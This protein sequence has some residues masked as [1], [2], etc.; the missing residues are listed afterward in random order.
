MIYI[1]KKKAGNEPVVKPIV[2]FEIN[3]YKFNE[4]Q[5]KP[6][7]SIVLKINDKNV[8]SYGSMVVLTG[9]PKARKSTFLH[10]ILASAIS[11]Q[12]IFGITITMQ[13]KKEKIILIDT[14]QSNYELFSSIERLCKLVDI[15]VNDIGKYNLIIYSARQLDAHGISDLVENIL[16]QHPDCGILAVDGAIDLINDINDVKE[17]KQIIQK[18]KY[19]IDK[20]NILFITIIHQNKST[21]FSL[22][23][24]GSFASR[25]AQSELSIEK[26]DNND[27]TLSATYMRSDENF[28]PVMVYYDSDLKTYKHSYAQK[29]SVIKDYNHEQ[30]INKLFDVKEKYLFKDLLI[31]LK[32]NYQQ[33]EYFVKN[34]IVPMLFDEKLIVKTTGGIMKY[35]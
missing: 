5:E 34:T 21:N 28:E 4:F 14:E 9:K 25:F 16:I 29:P 20:F 17:S 3:N 18:I 23:H 32:N 15:N 35:R 19:W 7:Q 11:K 33:S 2:Q 12:N 26:N 30:I 31:A 24:L 22:G 10:F 13:P 27:S 6:E 1:E 8:G